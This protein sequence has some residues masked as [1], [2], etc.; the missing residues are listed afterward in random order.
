MVGASSCSSDDNTLG[1]DENETKTVFLKLG[2][3]PTTYAEGSAKEDKAT[4]VFNNGHLY[5]A[6]AAGA[7]IQHYTIGSGTTDLTSAT[8]KYI[9]LEEF[10]TSGITL[11]SVPGSVTNVYIVANHPADATTPPTS[12]PASLPTTGPIGVVKN[13][14]LN[15]EHQGTFESVNL[16]G[17]EVLALVD[18]KWTAEV[19]LNPTVAR[20]ELTKLTSSHLITGYEVEGIF[21]DN[22]YATA[23]VNGTVGTATDNSGADVDGTLFM[24]GSSKY[25]V[26]LKPSIYDWYTV[27]NPLVAT[28]VV[29]TPKTGNV[30]GYNVFAAATGTSAVPRIIIRLKNITTEIGSGVSFANPQFLTIKNLKAGSVKIDNFEAGKIYNIKNLTFHGTNLTS[31]P[32]TKPIEVEVTVKLAK[33]SAVDTTP[34]L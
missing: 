1:T 28:G 17:E 29:A 20:I 22:Y 24:D 32:N 9:N 6:T 26:E 34:E 12:A 13:S 18:T 10:K 21:V 16:Y 3:G 27:A 15:V 23:T 33:W 5:L 31:A 25:G 8:N 7:I 30:W 14:V 2:D 19:T 11:S 4:V